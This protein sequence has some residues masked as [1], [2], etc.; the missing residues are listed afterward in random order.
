MAEIKKIYEDAARTTQVYPQTHEKAVVDNNGTTAETKFQMITELVQQE[1]MEVGAVPSDLTPTINSTNWVTSGGLFN[2]FYPEHTEV[3][4]S[5][6]TEN[7]YWI[8]DSDRTWRSSTA[9]HCILIPVEGNTNY[10]IIPE[11]GKSTR[12]SFLRSSNYSSGGTPTF[13]SGYSASDTS[14]NTTL[15][16]TSPVDAKYLYIIQQTSNP[17]YTW[18]EHLYKVSSL[19]DAYHAVL[20]VQTST[21]RTEDPISS[22]FLNNNKTRIRILYAC[23]THGRV[24]AKFDAPSEMST[25]QVILMKSYDVDDGTIDANNSIKSINLTIG[26]NGVMEWNNSEAQYILIN[27]FT[28][29]TMTDEI[30]NTFVANLTVVI[31]DLVGER[32][33]EQKVT[34]LEQTEINFNST[35][36]FGINVKSKGAVGNGTADDT[37]ALQA[38]LNEGGVVYIPNGTYL[39]SSSLK[40]YSNTHLIMDKNATILRNSNSVKCLIYTYWEATTTEYNGQHDITIEGGI[41]DLGT[42]YTQGGC[43]LGFL[44]CQ[45]LTI[46]DVTIKHQNSGYHCVDCGGSK[47]IRVENCLFTDCLTDNTSAEMFQFDS[48]TGS[49]AF[50]IINYPDDSA[51]YDNTP[52]VNVEI[53][54]C[55]FY[56]NDYS[57]A[58]GGHNRGPHSHI[59]IHDNFIYGTGHSRVRGAIAFGDVEWYGGDF[60]YIHDNFIDNFY[61]GFQLPPDRNI[62]VKNNIFTNVQNVLNPDSAG[63]GTFEG[64]YQVTVS[65]SS[66]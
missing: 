43:G 38:A 24:T 2:S 23:G 8:R 27:A 13:C 6:V 7:A 17:T 15:E 29:S 52:C 55:K 60:I 3:D 10:L 12:F 63:H 40:I 44:H 9:V 39:I 20:D 45:N 26:S 41:L 51:C 35:V 34:E 18:P 64:N 14:T 5:E 53:C 47:N 30:F 28:G 1:Q 22:R 11:S 59:N 46:R 4:F 25:V 36:L 16:V 33:L 50:P 56:T 54:G 66:E 62:W 31:E 65:A 49:A 32:G 19:K 58:I 61:N 42:G 48:P 57:P 37:T 21:T